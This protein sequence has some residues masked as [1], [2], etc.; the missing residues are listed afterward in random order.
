[1]THYDDYDDFALSD[2]FGAKTGGSKKKDSGNSC[3]S[4]KHVRRVEAI[5]LKASKS[6]TK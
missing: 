1:M 2:N 4:S 5:A 6:K 3:Y